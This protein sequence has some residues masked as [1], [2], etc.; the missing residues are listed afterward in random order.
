[1]S[2]DLGNTEVGRRALDRLCRGE[3]VLTEERNAAGA[4]A[5]FLFRQGSSCPLVQHQSALVENVVR[6]R[7]PLMDDVVQAR[8]ALQ[9]RNPFS[10]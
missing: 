2:R 5:G 3:E 10:R 7:S 1:M 8:Q 9:Q 4:Y 6:S